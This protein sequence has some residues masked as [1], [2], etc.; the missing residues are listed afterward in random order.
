VT[1]VN[2]VFSESPVA[3]AI[4]DYSAKREI[5]V[6]PQGGGTNLGGQVFNS[7]CIV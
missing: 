6:L 7:G 4:V 1:P 2:V 3:A 5:P